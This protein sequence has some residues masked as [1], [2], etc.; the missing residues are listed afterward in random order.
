MANHA[1]V[2]GIDR[3][4]TDLTSLDGPVADAHAFASWLLESGEVAPADLRLGLLPGRFSPPLP[5]ELSGCTPIGTTVSAL[6]KV[7]I[8]LLNAPPPDLERLYFFFS[9]HGAASS[10]PAYAEEAICLEGYT[11]DDTTNAL[12]ITSLMSVLNA[13]PAQ[14][15][16]VLIDGCRNKMFSDEIRF[17][18]LSRQPRT[19]DGQRRNFVL[20]ATGP[21]RKAAEVDGHGL[22]SRHLCEGLRGRG[23]AKRWDPNAADGDGGYL[24]RWEA[25]TQY[26]AAEVGATRAAQRHEQLIFLGGEHPAEDNPLMASF[27]ADHFGMSRVVVQLTDPATPPER[28]TVLLRRNDTIDPPLSQPLAAGRIEFEVQPSVWV[29]G[30]QAAGWNSD[31][32]SARVDVYD[33]RVDVTLKLKQIEPPRMADAPV[34]SSPVLGSLIGHPAAPFSQALQPTGDGKLRLTVGGRPLGAVRPAVRVAVRRESGDVVADPVAGNE[35]MLPPGAYR[36]RLDL[37]G[38]TWTEIPVLITPADDET[39]DLPMPDTATAALARTL[40]A[41]NKP[42]PGGGFALPSEAMGPLAAPSVA[43]VAAIAVVQAVNG[44]GYGLA[45]LAIGQRWAAGVDIGAEVLIADERDAPDPDETFAPRARLWQMSS[46]NAKP[47]TGELTATNAQAP[48]E[49]CSLVVEPGG[50]WLQFRD[51]DRKRRAG[52]KLATQVLP[53]H[54]TLVVRHQLS[55]GLVSLHQYAVRRNEVER[56]ATQFGVVQSEA[57]QRTRAA[58]RDPVADPALRDLAKGEWFEPFSAMVAAA[59]LLER[60]DAGVALF[61]QVLDALTRHD[62]RGADVTV[63]RAA[64]AARKGRDDLAAALL[65]DAL[66][67]GQAPLVDALLERLDAEARRLGIASDRTAWIARKL[68][69]TVGH[70]LWTLRREDDQRQSGTPDVT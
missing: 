39:L 1:I 68:S 55:S 41:G 20:R 4:A 13:T 3:Y 29:L 10:N 59:A 21:G 44:G 58:G 26:V 17:G 46:H 64:Q 8:G 38:G 40:A 63:L 34:K 32:K 2:I 53:G 9:G 51:Q 60:G 52:F 25:L 7:L 11:D 45:A 18:A 54:V 31:P 70:P 37:P 56:I 48:I 49:S 28:T 35:L 62:I 42:P 67:L 14:Q 30:A 33:D 61:D 16:F 5:D 65:R 36:V 43:T 22:F 57:F 24:V 6:N 12:E 23:S 50:W 47:V 19:A 27:A 69:Q 66:G 15:R